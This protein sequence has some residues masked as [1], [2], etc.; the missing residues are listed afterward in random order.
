M[1]LV[2]WLI[3]FFFFGS[4]TGKTIAF[5]QGVPNTKLYRRWWNEIDKKNSK[6]QVALETMGKNSKK[7]RGL[8]L[9]LSFTY[10]PKSL[11]C[12]KNYR[13]HFDSDIVA[14]KTW[15]TQQFLTFWFNP[16]SVVHKEIR[17]PVRKLC[18]T[19]MHCCVGWLPWRHTHRLCNEKHVCRCQEH[20]RVAFEVFK[21]KSMQSEKQPF[22]GTF[23]GSLKSETTSKG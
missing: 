21:L 23:L 1:I 9:L 17:V 4:W 19:T 20:H 10:F 5:L 15:C 12:A 14:D 8:L 6:G 18:M 2:D 3:G 13:S 7:R 16:W 22:W 11:H